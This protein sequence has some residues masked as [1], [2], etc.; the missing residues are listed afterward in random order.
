MLHI[1]PRA[2]VLKNF[3][4]PLATKFTYKMTLGGKGLWGQGPALYKHNY[5][6]TFTP[7]A[8]GAAQDRHPTSD[9][10]CRGAAAER[11]IFPT[12]SAEAT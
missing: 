2:T 11:I 12:S 8:A 7:A 4:A 6:K 3:D 1:S 10:V 9:P 5:F